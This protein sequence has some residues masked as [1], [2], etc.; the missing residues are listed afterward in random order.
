MSPTIHHINILVT[1]LGKAVERFSALLGQTPSLESLP[2][3]GAN[4]ARFKCG[5]T[6]LVLVS[7]VTRESVLHQ[8]LERNGEGVFLLSFTSNSLED[9]LANL[10]VKGIAP[11]HEEPRKGLSNWWVTD[12][13]VVPDLPTVIQL[14]EE[15]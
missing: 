7:P 8:Y 9:S 3:R 15:R 10:A 4:T 1:D 11:C 6:Y 12:I 13:D 14:C 5:E 2:Q